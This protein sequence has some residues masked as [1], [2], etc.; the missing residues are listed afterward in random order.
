MTP[1][2]RCLAGIA[3]LSFGATPAS[4]Q[5]QAGRRADQ[6]EP[7]A[8]R[9]ELIVIQD[10]N[11]FSIERR[12]APT[13]HSSEPMMKAPIALGAAHRIDRSIFVNA[14]TPAGEK[15]NARR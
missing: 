8:K 6:T 3:I 9:G 12:A 5:F 4:A 11:G 10:A 13:R 15:R 14:V 7:F 2:N 1:Y